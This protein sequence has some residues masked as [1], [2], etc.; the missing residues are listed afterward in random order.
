MGQRLNIEIH[1]NGKPL[2]NCYYH[3]GGYTKSALNTIQELIS[4]ASTKKGVIDVKKA[5]EIFLEQGA[6]IEKSQTQ[7]LVEQSKE[8]NRNSGLI[9]TTK[10]YM[11][12]TRL[13]QEM[14]AVIDVGA[15][16]ADIRGLFFE[17]EKEDYDGES[18]IEDLYI[19]L[20]DLESVDF[21][22]IPLIE[23]IMHTQEAFVWDG[24]IQIGND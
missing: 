15:R 24:V 23:E 22:D 5:V 17:V 3:W 13:W 8:L 10:R 6:T 20:D 18:E 7:R 1:N 16:K 14:G 9:G 2:A 4:I 11:D 21:E 19:M 12:T